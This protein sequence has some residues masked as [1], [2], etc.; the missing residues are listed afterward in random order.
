MCELIC[1]LTQKCFTSYSLDDTQIKNEPH[2]THEL[3]S[4]A[5]DWLKTYGE[6]LLSVYIEDKPKPLTLVEQTNLISVKD[7]VTFSKIL[8]VLIEKFSEKLS[9]DQDLIT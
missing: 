9:R 7:L 8:L 1:D 5:P 6:A 3:L 4:E 2:E